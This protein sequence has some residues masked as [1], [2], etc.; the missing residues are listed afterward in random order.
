MEIKKS[1]RIKETDNF[2]SPPFPTALELSQDQNEYDQQTL[3][4][5]KFLESFAE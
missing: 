5:I 2:N 4:D 3:E 1:N